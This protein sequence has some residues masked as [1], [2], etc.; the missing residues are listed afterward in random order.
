MIYAAFFLIMELWSGFI[1]RGNYAFDPT[2][3]LPEWGGI[4][5]NDLLMLPSFWG[6]VCLIMGI[7]VIKCEKKDKLAKENVEAGNTGQGANLALGQPATS[8]V[9]APPPPAGGEVVQ[10]P[11]LAVE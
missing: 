1:W 6:V 7:I 5:S 2:M 4:W 11:V 8:I 9:A 10:N 3:Y